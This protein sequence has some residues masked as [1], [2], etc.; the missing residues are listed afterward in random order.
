LGGEVG[1]EEGLFEDALLADG[2]EGVILCG[3]HRRGRRW[4][5]R[6]G[7][8]HCPQSQEEEQ[9]SCSVKR[10]AGVEHSFA[11]FCRLVFVE[12]H[13]ARLVFKDNDHLV[14]V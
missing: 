8:H 7:A 2:D 13:D 4:G 14:S 9:A 10:R 3:R 5:S 12:D 11:R 1:G 6:A